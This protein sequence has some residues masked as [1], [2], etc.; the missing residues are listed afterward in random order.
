MVFDICIK[1]ENFGEIYGSYIKSTLT[2]VYLSNVSSN[3]NTNSV[4][5]L[6]KVEKKF[7]LSI[8]RMEIPSF[9]N[10]TNSQLQ[11]IIALK[12]PIYIEKAM[13]ILES[14]QSPEIHDLRPEIKLEMSK[15][16][17]KN[18]RNSGNTKAV[19]SEWNQFKANEE[20]FG[21]KSEFDMDEYAEK[22]DRNA[23]GYKEMKSQSQRIAKEIMSQPNSDPHRQ[24]ERE[25]SSRGR[26]TTDDQLYSSVQNTSKWNEVL[27]KNKKNNTENNKK[28]EEAQK[29][30]NIQ[31]SILADKAAEANI[32]LEAEKAA[33]NDA[34][35][36]GG[37]PGILE[38]LKERKLQEDLAK[39]AARIAVPEP[40]REL[41]L[42]T[43]SRE[44]SPKPSTE[45]N[46]SRQSKSKDRKFSGN[47]KRTSL[48]TKNGS[49]SQPLKFSFA[50][51][52]LKHVLNAF[53]S[54]SSDKIRSWGNGPKKDGLLAKHLKPLEN[55]PFSAERYKEIAAKITESNLKKTKDQEVSAE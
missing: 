34:F 15:Q 26:S 3:P 41:V 17:F 38:I 16:N 37:Y 33:T 7:I 46:S 23:P 31:K 24:E 19:K 39:E 27:E 14:R 12:N 50:D 36:K 43:S 28:V 32:L 44:R 18:E 9:E 22:I 42:E 4:V 54:N 6:F 25:L 2:S 52:L 35:S 8:K 40:T 49:F 47:P 10:F 13:K 1:M 11:E 5:A 45:S 55:I 20:K 51:L 30:S 29:N 53:K 48:N 21:I